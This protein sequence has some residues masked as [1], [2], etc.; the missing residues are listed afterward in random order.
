MNSFEPF[1]ENDHIIHQESL[2]VDQEQV[3]RISKAYIRKIKV[4][5]QVL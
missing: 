1:L 3:D 2:E 4:K 5:N